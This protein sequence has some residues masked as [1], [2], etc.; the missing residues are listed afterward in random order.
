MCLIFVAWRH[1][2][3]YPLIIAANRDEFY[4]RPTAQAHFWEDAPHVL[5]GRDGKCG[6]TWFGITRGG[7]FAAVTNF[8]DPTLR[9]DDARSRGQLV[10]DYLTGDAAPAEYLAAVSRQDAAYGP[11]NLVVGDSAGVRYYSSRTH[12]MRALAPGLFGL[13]NRFLDTPWPKVAKGK[14]A[15]AQRL[16]SVSV[17]PEALFEVLAD[18]SR[19]PDEA[20]PDTGV[21]IEWERTL[22]P[23]FI[24]SPTYGTRSSTV[25]TVDRTARVRFIERSW[26]A[27]GGE[28]SVAAYDFTI[29]ERAGDAVATG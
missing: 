4:V 14:E 27:D 3:R 7:R 26:T 10:R 9:N 20:L 25:V 17:R 2:S 19:P 29:G 8:R 11:F 18:R 1:H 16:S 22:S 15:M 23:A 28:V 5:A 21:G 6:G 12:E 13:S 24:V